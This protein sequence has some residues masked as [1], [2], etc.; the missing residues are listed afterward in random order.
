MQNLDWIQDYENINLFEIILNILL[1]FKDARRATLIEWN[2]FSRDERGKYEALGV[3]FVQELNLFLLPDR[4]N[5][6][7]TFVVKDK[8]ISAPDSEEGVGE[9]L[10]FKCAGHSFNDHN[11][12]RLFGHINEVHTRK[13]IYSEICVVDILSIEDFTSSLNEKVIKFNKA[14]QSLELKYRFEYLI[15]ES[16]PRDLLLVN[17]RNKEFVSKHLKNYSELLYNDF[18]QKTKF[19]KNSKLILE[20]FDDVF[21]FVMQ[22]IEN[23]DIA[24]LYESI[25]PSSNEYY[26]LVQSLV[27]LENQLF[28]I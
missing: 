5:N 7:R 3:K 21:E 22:L 14:M 15:E 23:G 20:R 2:N 8:T 9:L 19:A 27:D 11:S 28:K 24:K 1:V 10:E 25:V 6:Q 13:N 16:V 12:N 17:R 26:V 18:H 4:S